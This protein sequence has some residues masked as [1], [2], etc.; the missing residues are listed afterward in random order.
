MEKELNSATSFSETT[1]QKSNYTEFLDALCPYCMMYGMTY[2]EFWFSNMNRFHDYWQK[3]EYER[4]KRNQELWLQGM[5]VW[6]AVA[7]VLDSK[8]KIKYP[9]KPYRL[10]EMTEAEKEAEAK[11]KVETMR[12]QLLEIKRRWDAKNK[13]ET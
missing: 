4:E 6:E 3:H 1:A 13:G 7:S 10:T 9:D 5:Y 12:Q 2:E 11:K 8:H